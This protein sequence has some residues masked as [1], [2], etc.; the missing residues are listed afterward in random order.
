[1]TDTRD[2]IVSE[3]VGSRFAFAVDAVAAWHELRERYLL[4][5]DPEPLPDGEREVLARI[6]SYADVTGLALN[7]AALLRVAWAAKHSDALSEDD[8]IDALWGASELAGLIARLDH[9]REDVDHRLKLAD[10]AEMA[11][12]KPARRRR[13]ERHDEKRKAEA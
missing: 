8:L 4:V 2:H 6:S 9:V 10:L 12:G 1:M 11:A 7:L 13:S 3:L 5:T